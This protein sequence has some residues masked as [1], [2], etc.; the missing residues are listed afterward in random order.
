MRSSNNSRIHPLASAGEG[1]GLRRHRGAVVIGAL[2]L[3]LS[4]FYNVTTPLWE[5]DNE[6]SHYQYVRYIAT[7]HKLPATRAVIPLT[8]TN[9]ECD[10]TIAGGTSIPYQFRQPPLYYLL[11]TIGTVG[12]DLSQDWPV[13]DNPHSFMPFNRG[14]INMAV[15]RDSERFPY[16]GTARAVHQ[17]R[18]VSGLIGLAGVIA[19]Y[20]SGCL[21]F[22]GRRSLALVLAAVY[23]WNPQVIF[24]ASVINNDIL[25]ATLGAWC[26]YFCLRY[27]L[28]KPQA[29]TLIAAVLAA[30]LA[31]LAKYSAVLL[32]P[33]L[34]L[35]V[36]ISLAQTWQRERSRFAARLAQIAGLLAL[37]ALPAALWLLSNR[38]RTGHWFSVYSDVTDSF[39]RDTFINP[40]TIPNGRLF[41]VPYAIN[42]ALMTFWG[43][44][45]NDNVA[46]PSALV[47]ALRIVFL[48]GVA[49]ALVLLFSRNQ[50]RRLRVAVAAALAVIAGAVVINL[51]RASG[52]SEPRGRYFLPVYAVI[53]FVLVAGIDRLL[54]S[55]LRRPGA[56]V[57]PAALLCVALAV[58][59]LVLRPSYAPPAVAASTELRAG[60]QPLA[61]RFD[62]FAELIGYRVEQEQ[63]GLYQ[64]TEVTLVWRA[65]R[66]TPNNYTV[67]VTLLDGANRSLDRHTSFPGRGNFATSLWQP[68]QVFRDV[69]WVGMG[70]SAQDGLPSLGR[71]SVAM[72]CY[73]NAGDRYL[74]VSDD[75]GQSL[76]NS[77]S[78]GRLKLA[79]PDQ[80]PAAAPLPMLR[81]GDLIA[82]ERF[83][84]T[85]TAYPFG[86]EMAL[87]FDWA[88]LGQPAKDYTLFIHLVDQAGNTLAG[89]DRPLTEGYYPSSLWQAGERIPHRQPLPMPSTLPAGSYTV[90]IG[91]YDPATG[92]RLPITDAA[93][94]AQ[95]N[96]EATL[97]TL[98]SPGYALFLPLIEQHQPAAAPQP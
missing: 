69:Y 48:I 27:L 71:V 40:V 28:H 59:P 41:D 13:S 91:L 4:L 73:N 36:L 56:A 64:P 61:V 81:F 2:F 26:V 18:L 8:P 55:R 12:V 63:I 95:A 89:N 35:T 83:S 52:T 77:I 90:R 68:G 67:A 60:E 75:Q 98:R 9:D 94:V 21:L 20:A 22:R 6:W 44:F 25:T 16:Q 87:D 33:V 76:G 46:L 24:S 45:G 37:S 19:V 74:P 34:G 38:L 17:I 54:P 84:A 85:P 30:S 7:Q 11:G 51:I 97:L 88:V 3:T 78:F 50:P 32:V 53:C 62:D 72:Y 66:A 39:V 80:P 42:F 93:G 15:H 43:L 57:L 58:P 5:S 1:H 10:E 86:A 82:L 29:R 65:L 14:G 31:L 92:E 70:S 49:G 96:G 23:A 79:A 47:A